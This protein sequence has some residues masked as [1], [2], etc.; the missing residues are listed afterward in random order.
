MNYDSL[1]HFADSYGLLFL[2]LVFVG[3]VAWTFRRNARGL[4]EQASMSIFEN[5]DQPDGR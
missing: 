4:H 2:A 3:V 1:R 5:R